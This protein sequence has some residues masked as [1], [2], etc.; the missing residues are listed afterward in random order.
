MFIHTY[1]YLYCILPRSWYA[2]QR[3][4]S[5]L[6]SSAENLQGPARKPESKTDKTEK[7]SC[8]KYVQIVF[9]AFEM[10]FQM[11]HSVCASKQCHLCIAVPS[12]GHQVPK[13]FQCTFLDLER[14]RLQQIFSSATAVTAAQVQVWIAIASWSMSVARSLDFSTW[15]NDTNSTANQGTSRNSTVWPAT[16]HKFLRLE[17]GNHLLELC[18]CL[19]WRRPQVRSQNEENNEATWRQLAT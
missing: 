5:S 18:A 17:D 3:K 15:H 14:S 1:T 10:V 9:A 11:F 7:H 2:P 19:L 12:A 8:F 4:A 16:C 6:E 13:T